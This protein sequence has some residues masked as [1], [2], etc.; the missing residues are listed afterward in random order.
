MSTDFIALF[1]VTVEG[2]NPQ[3]LAD[4]MRE[5]PA[6]FAW[7]VKAYGAHFRAQEWVAE[8]STHPGRA[9]EV[10]GPGGFILRPTARLLEL[11]HGIRFSAFTGDGTHR[12]ALRGVCL[13]LAAL[14]GSPRAIYTHEL[15]P[16]SGYGDLAAVEAGLRDVI[17]P[18]ARTFD[19]LH[20]A[21]YFAPRAWYIDSLGPPFSQ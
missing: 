18:P 1:D 8:P 17:G 12:D 16:Y 20:A 15:M 10:V 4:R 21:E 13:E 2:V 6:L 19:E 11:W 3:W 5:R 7:F 9:L 14:V